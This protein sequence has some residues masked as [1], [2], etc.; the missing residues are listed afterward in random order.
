MW[1]V[2][3]RDPDYGAAGWGPTGYLHLLLPGLRIYT[4]IAGKMRSRTHEG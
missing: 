1:L 4:N 3:L 2:I